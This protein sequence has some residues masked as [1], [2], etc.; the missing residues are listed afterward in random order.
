MQNL[1]D[2]LKIEKEVVLEFFFYF[3][4][5]EYA[6]KRENFIPK[7]DGKASADWDSFFSKQKAHIDRLCLQHKSAKH[8]LENLPKKQMIKNGSLVWVNR[9]NGDEPDYVRL[10]NGIRDIRNN[11]FHGGKFPYESIEEPSRNKM[12]IT[13]ATEIL[14]ELGI[15][16]LSQHFKIEEFG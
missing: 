16:L 7:R 11:L 4:R 13:S 14:K 2:Q 12:L 8:I 1:I 5:F 6:L 3:S 15:S 10:N 9:S